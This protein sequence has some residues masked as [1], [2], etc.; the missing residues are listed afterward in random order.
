M[1]ISS[2]SATLRQDGD[3]FREL[4]IVDALSGSL[5]QGYDIFH[6]MALHTVRDGQDH[7]GEVDV[8]VM[9]PSGALLLMEVKAGSVALRDGQVYKLYGDREVDVGR[10]C[11]MQR[12][13]LLSRLHDAGIE[14]GVAT[15]LVIPDFHL[16]DEHVVSVPRERIVDAALF[17]MLTSLV[18][19][20]LG[21]MRGCT[22][23]ESLR[24]FLHNQ[25]R[26]APDLSQRSLNY[27][28]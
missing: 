8:V 19:E 2:M 28:N 12:A 27:G 10:Q 14:T 5:P 9:A 16:A 6:S 17:P 15:C 20:W 1:L 26:M 4:D 3:R 21:G 11:R 7:Y 13:S 23:L 22:Q 24:H 18:R 25:F